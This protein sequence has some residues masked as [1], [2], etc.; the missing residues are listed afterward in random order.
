MRTRVSFLVTTACLLAL[1]APAWAGR[2]STTVEIDHA[3]RIATAR[4]KPGN[5]QLEANENTGQV[6]VLRDG[7]LV[8]HVKGKWVNLNRKSEYSEMLTDNHRV[9]EVRFAGKKKAIK[10]R[11]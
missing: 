3:T 2:L 6:K 9:Q 10:F 8:A 1:S 4:L 5:Y 11:S 7:R